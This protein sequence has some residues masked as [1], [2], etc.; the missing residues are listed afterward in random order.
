MSKLK[1]VFIVEAL[2]PADFYEGCLDG[3]A[4]GEMLRILGTRME[5]RIAFTRPLIERAIGEAKAGDF[6]ILHVSSHGDKTGIEITNGKELNW[7][8][9]VDLI[10]PAS[11]PDK[12]LV[13]AT[14]GGGDV[15][16][17]KALVAAGVVFGWVFG[18]TAE[19]VH[20]SDSCIAWSIL[21][22]RLFD[23]GF[24]RKDL[25]V[26]LKAI[27]AAIVGD[28]VYRRWDGK[29]YRRYPSST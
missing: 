13:M 28:F 14:C 18:S 27:N 22:N 21:Y 15:E 20:F 10:K 26:T 7:A 17:T 19:S 11:G 9:F 16:L 4:A 25:M 29:K 8:E 12:A 1:S 23:H 3:R 5:Y 2:R 24:K 6:E